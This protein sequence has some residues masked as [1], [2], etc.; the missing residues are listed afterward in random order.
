MVFKLQGLKVRRT[1]PLSIVQVSK[2]DWVD[3]GGQVV[4]G[5]RL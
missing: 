4:T 5:C 3:G 1:V 2:I